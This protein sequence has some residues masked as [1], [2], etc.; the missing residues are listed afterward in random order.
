MA[1]SVSFV[2]EMKLEWKPLAEDAELDA[3][4]ATGGNGA[5]AGHLHV[6]GERFR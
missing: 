2:A 5:P 4:M 6:S 1:V 3:E